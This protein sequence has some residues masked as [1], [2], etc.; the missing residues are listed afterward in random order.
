MKHSRIAARLAPVAALVAAV[1]TAAAPVPAAQAAAVAPAPYQL[2]VIEHNIAGGP[3]FE[4]SREA[5]NQVNAQM[6]AFNPDVVMLTEVCASQRDAFVQEH[7]GWTVYFSVMVE[8]QPSCGRDSSNPNLRQGQLLAS[9]HPMA[10]VTNDN[11]GD[12]DATDPN[13]VK[14][15]KLLCAD[16]KIGD[17]APDSLRACVTHLRAFQN[18][19]AQ[20]ARERQTARIRALLHDRIWTQGQAVTVGGD[21]NALPNFNAMDSL[22]YLNRGSQFSGEGDFHEAEQTDPQW[23]GT[24]G[25]SVTCGAT[26]CRTGQRTI[27]SAK[28]DYLFISRNVTHGGRVSGLVT[29]RCPVAQEQDPN[30]DCSDH[31]LYRAFFDITY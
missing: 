20:A 24:H 16:V 13:R 9:K 3:N 17:R 5:L 28:Y 26:V 19:T 6:T 31:Y 15:F 18:D 29:Q 12:P 27:G 22:Y 8:V 2:R 4:G 1:V 7:P 11:L 30:Q 10:N 23:F 21:F 14:Q 25:P